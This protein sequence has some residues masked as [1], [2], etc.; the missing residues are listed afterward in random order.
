MV[1]RRQFLV[2]EAKKESDNVFR[3]LYEKD[4]AWESM[5]N[6]SEEYAFQKLTDQV[7]ESVGL[8]KHVVPITYDTVDNLVMCYSGCQ[9][10][11]IPCK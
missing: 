8:F 9:K 7:V 3:E 6:W 11:K 1:P 5:Y 10:Y 2:C 4:R